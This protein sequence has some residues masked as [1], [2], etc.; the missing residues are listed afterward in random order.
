MTNTL[1]LR[2]LISE[3]GIKYIHIAEKLGITSYSLQL[4]IENKN[5]FKQSEIGKFC[6]VLNIE[7][8]EEKERLFFAKDVD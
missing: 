4:K 1:E 6:D 8:L 7:S 5:E 2:K 3:K